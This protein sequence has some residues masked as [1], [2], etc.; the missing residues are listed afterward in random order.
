MNM[1]KE[2]SQMF[3]KDMKRNSFIV[4]VKMKIMIPTKN[5]SNKMDLVFLILHNQNLIHQLKEK[6]K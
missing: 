3:T 1:N 2:F 4:K 6:K 5:K